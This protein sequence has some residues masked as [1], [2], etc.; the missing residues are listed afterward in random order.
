[1]KGTYIMKEL[2]AENFVTLLKVNWLP[3]DIFLKTSIF[4]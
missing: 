1:M 2:K 3:T 4:F